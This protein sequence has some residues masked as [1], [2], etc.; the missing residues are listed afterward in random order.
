[1]KKSSK[2]L[3]VVA[4][5]AARRVH[6][7]VQALATAN[8]HLERQKYSE[9]LLAGSR[10]QHLAHIDGA[11]ASGSSALHFKVLNRSVLNLDKGLHQVA[12]KISHVED[13]REARK[14]DWDATR[15]RAELIGRVV[16]RRRDEEGAQQQRNAEIAVDDNVSSTYRPRVR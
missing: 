10:E 8:R 6:D 15:A 13:E 16:Q 7:A 2:R 1:M 12:D 4:K 5:L 14:A 9:E 3:A 11:L